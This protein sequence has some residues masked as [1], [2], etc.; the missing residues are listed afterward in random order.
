MGVRSGRL[1]VT[2]MLDALIIVMFSVLAIAAL[3]LH[4]HSTIM[5][6]YYACYYRQIYKEEQRNED[7]LCS[8]KVGNDKCR[9][10]PYL[11]K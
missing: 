6:S 5:K 3:G 8:G 10:C 11:K 2:L 9:R 7:E 1:G 4:I